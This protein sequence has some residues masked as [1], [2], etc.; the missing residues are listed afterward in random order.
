MMRNKYYQKKDGCPFKVHPVSNG[1]KDAFTLVEL[2]VVIAIMCLLIALLFPVLANSLEWARRVGCLSNLR[3]IANGA[4]C[5]ASDFNGY[6]PITFNQWD[7]DMRLFY[8]EYVSELQIFNCPSTRNYVTNRNDLRL[9]AAHG[10]RCKGTSYEYWAW[11]CG[12]YFMGP[13]FHR[14]RLSD[15]FPE[16]MTILADI[17]NREKNLILDP[18]DNHGI[19]GGNALF[20][21]LHAKWQEIPTG[22]T[23]T[24]ANLQGG[25]IDAYRHGENGIKYKW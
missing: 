21:D 10:G 14:R 16:V 13:P 24:W 9:N 23:K 7:D 4:F 6:V 8:S 17:D 1:M 15:R 5:Y 19:K 18:S 2:L 12:A 3:N 20:L 22:D 11:C 25:L